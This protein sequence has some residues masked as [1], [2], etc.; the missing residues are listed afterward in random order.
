[1]WLLGFLIEGKSVNSI[2]KK[3]LLSFQTVDQF[4]L[5][6]FIS[7]SFWVQLWSWDVSILEGIGS[8]FGLLWLQVE[9]EI[10]LLPFQEVPRVVNL[11]KWRISNT[12]VLFEISCGAG[13][14][15]LCW[16]PLPWFRQLPLLIWS[17]AFPSFTVSLPWVS[18]SNI[19]MIEDSDR[20]INNFA[21]T[22][23]GLS[24]GEGWM[25]LKVNTFSWSQKFL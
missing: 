10:C 19:S 13:Q 2:L 7:L 6:R 9:R 11:S 12:Y 5:R 14:F 25:I 16:L 18:C 21:G 23:G 24:D 4:H 8:G 17:I 3:K 15:S 22:C 20:S 1:M